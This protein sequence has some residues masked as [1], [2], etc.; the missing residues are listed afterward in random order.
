METVIIR[1]CRTVY[2]LDDAL[3]YMERGKHNNRVFKT[4]PD[5][6]GEV[7][8]LDDAEEMLVTEH[9]IFFTVDSDK[10]R[11]YCS[12][13]DGQDVRCINEM[14]VLNLAIYGDYLY[15]CQGDAYYRDSESGLTSLCR[16]RVY[17][18]E[19]TDPTPLYEPECILNNDVAYINA[20]NGRVYFQDKSNQKVLQYYNVE[21]GSTKILTREAAYYPQLLGSKIFYLE[22]G[23]S[24]EK[25]RIYKFITV[26]GSLIKMLE[27]H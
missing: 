27:K 21:D 7:Q 3:F 22:D 16:M 20:E 14:P 12:S 17:K 23:P 11:L 10:P 19:E 8:I 5:G 24:V 4:N 25:G 2:V 6:S 13:L 26:N 9:N 15:Y 1:P 18:S